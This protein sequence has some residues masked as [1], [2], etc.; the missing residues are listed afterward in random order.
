MSLLDPWVRCLPC[1]PFFLC[2][3]RIEGRLTLIKIKAAIIFSSKT[4]S[5]NRHLRRENYLNRRWKAILSFITH[6]PL[7]ERILR[8]RIPKIVHSPIPRRGSS[9]PVAP[10]DAPAKKH[11]GLAQGRQQT[12][13]FDSARACT[14]RGRRSDRVECAPVAQLE[15]RLASDQ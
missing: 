1:F 8:L 2:R 12:F 7:G 14:E 11:G 10:F 9:A 6:R 3:Q 5:K 4:S 15:E 13:F